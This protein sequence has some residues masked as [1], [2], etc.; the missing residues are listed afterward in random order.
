MP[1]NSAVGPY[2]HEVVPAVHREHAEDVM[3][4]DRI[5]RGEA[6]LVEEPDDPRDHQNRADE[7]AVEPR[8]TRILHPSLLSQMIHSLGALVPNCDGALQVDHGEMTV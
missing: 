1:T 6:G 7:Q 8:G 5:P 3:C 4:P 2:V